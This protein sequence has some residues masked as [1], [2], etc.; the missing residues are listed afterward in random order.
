[1]HF[2]LILVA[3]VSTVHLNG[4]ESLCLSLVDSAVWSDQKKTPLVQ[5]RE[6]RSPSTSDQRVR[7]G[8]AR[9]RPGNKLNH[10]F[11][12]VVAKLIE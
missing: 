3:P 1:M 8:C 9:T 4:T 7:L 11:L 10:P 2:W 12:R 5:E 6:R